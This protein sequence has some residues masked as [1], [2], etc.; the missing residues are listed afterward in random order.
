VHDLC[1]KASTYRR[2]TSQTR[3]MSECR[4]MRNWYQHHREGG[5]DRGRQT[6]LTIAARHSPSWV[7]KTRGWE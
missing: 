5:D 6:A 4:T 7:A 3:Y 2:S 1:T